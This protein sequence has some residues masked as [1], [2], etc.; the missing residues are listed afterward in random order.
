MQR[1]SFQ[2][3]GDRYRLMRAF[4]ELDDLQRKLDAGVYDQREVDDVIVTLR[5]VVQDNRPRPKC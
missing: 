2:S 4:D 1:E 5:D 3:G